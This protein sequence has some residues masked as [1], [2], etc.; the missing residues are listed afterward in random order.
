MILKT[1]EACAVT[2]FAKVAVTVLDDVVVDVGAPVMAPVV[3]LSVKPS[4]RL[5]LSKEGL[6]PKGT[7]VKVT[8]VIDEPT[9]PFTLL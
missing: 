2:P 7:T 6:L 9:D 3:K 4:G 1:I 8:G 5:F